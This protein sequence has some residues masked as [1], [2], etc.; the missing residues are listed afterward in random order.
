MPIK[1]IVQDILR[2]YWPHLL[3]IATFGVALIRWRTALSGDADTETMQFRCFSG[4]LI[5]LALV[6]AAGEISEWTGSYGWTR[7]Q[8]HAHSEEF[9]RFVGWLLLVGGTVAL[10]F[11]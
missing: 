8:H 11:V 4:A 7:D 2:S 9:V 5:G 6:L 3:A 1:D 10:F